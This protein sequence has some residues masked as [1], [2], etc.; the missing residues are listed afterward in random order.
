MIFLTHVQIHQH[1]QASFTFQNLLITYVNSVKYCCSYCTRNNI[2][3]LLED[4]QFVSLHHVIEYNCIAMLK[5]AWSG[6][7]WRFAGVQYIEWM[8]CL[9]IICNANSNIN[10]KVRGGHAWWI[11]DVTC[12]QSVDWNGSSHVINGWEQLCSYI[13][14]TTTDSVFVKRT[15]RRTNVIIKLWYFYNE[16]KIDCNIILVLIKPWMKNFF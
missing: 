10:Y 12:I 14:R 11:K 3:M 2:C 5:R 15:I 7:K 4:K 16:P 13:V 9:H 1:F 8:N 6:V